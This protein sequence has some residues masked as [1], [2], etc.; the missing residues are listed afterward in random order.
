LRSWKVRWPNI[1]S[2]TITQRRLTHRSIDRLRII[3][4]RTWSRNV[5]VGRLACVFMR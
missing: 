1:G 5:N 2:T 4:A 3:V